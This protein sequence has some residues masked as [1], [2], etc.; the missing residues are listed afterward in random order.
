M[1]AIA[2]TRQTLASQG[3]QPATVATETPAPPAA[4][5]AAA[6][7]KLTLVAQ[8]AVQ[9]AIARNPMDDRS[10]AFTADMLRATGVPFEVEA[11]E[12]LLVNGYAELA[13]AA[14]APLL[15]DGKSDGGVDLVVL[16]YAVPDMQSAQLPI[17]RITA[18]HPGVKAAFGVADA[19]VVAPFQAVALAEVFATRFGYRRVAVVALDQCSLPYEAVAQPY[20]VARVDSA[21]VVVFETGA[22]AGHV[23]VQRSGVGG[24][25]DQH[26]AL[27]E[28]FTELVDHAG[29]YPDHLVLGAGVDPLWSP[30]GGNHQRSDL[31]RVPVGSPCTGVW[32]RLDGRREH[33]VVA[34]IESDPSRGQV[35]GILLPPSHRGDAT[36]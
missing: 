35:H 12:N 22:G 4:R 5:A 15:G 20:Q 18:E 19:G 3:C 13:L 26:R 2:P 21:A 9:F 28:V 23:A 30:A 27:D 36:P 16:A 14:L 7:R 31:E 25:A 10:R 33:D 17:A 34:L 8:H 6:R 11:I 32:S 29:L 24:G 1:Y